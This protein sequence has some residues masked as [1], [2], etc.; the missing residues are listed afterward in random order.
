MTP[1]C[2]ALRGVSKHEE[3]RLK[4][5]FVC[6]A[7]AASSWLSTP[8]RVRNFHVSRRGALHEGARRTQLMHEMRERN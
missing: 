8:G 5:L 6:G 3:N 2:Q 7:D 4:A 1:L